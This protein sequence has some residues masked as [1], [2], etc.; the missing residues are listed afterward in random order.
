MIYVPTMYA[1]VIS[2][3]VHELKIIPL[4]FIANVMACVSPLIIASPSTCAD[5]SFG[6]K[7]FGIVAIGA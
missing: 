6:A 1:A 5:L 4:V 3:V 2:D 7:S